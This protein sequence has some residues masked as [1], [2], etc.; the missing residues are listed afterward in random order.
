MGNNRNSEV[1][2]LV[3]SCLRDVPA[4]LT[5][6]KENCMT[7]NLKVLVADGSLWEMI[8]LYLVLAGYALSKP[9]RKG[10]CG[11]VNGVEFHRCNRRT[12]PHFLAKEDADA[13]VTGYDLL[14]ASDA[15]GLREVC[16]LCFSRNSNGPTRWVLAR[17]KGFDPDGRKVRIGCELPRLAKKL[18]KERTLPFDF[19]IE[20]I[21]GSE[22]AY[23]AK[24]LVDMVLVVTETGESL[25]AFDLEIVP[26]FDCLLESTPVLLAQTLLDA[27]KEA[28]LQALNMALQAVVGASAHVMVTFNVPAHVGIA[29]LRLP[30]GVAPTVAPLSDPRWQACT[31]CI[32]RTELGDVLCK[33]RQ[34][35]AKSIVMQEIQG[36]IA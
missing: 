36:F 3:K 26:G 29:L 25:R 17:R 35:G 34:A 8:L 21:D 7:R 5:F 12:I 18:L 4:A 9:D 14:Y 15:R 1:V 31:V 6:S 24:R 22:E 20:K 16:R 19:T 33:L 30:A 23:A 13:G 32:R 27:G 2:D 28:T 11:T 10:Y